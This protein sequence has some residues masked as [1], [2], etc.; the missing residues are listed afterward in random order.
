MVG[1]AQ[2]K[3]R[4]RREEM[5]WEPNHEGSH[6][7]AEGFGLDLTGKTEKEKDFSAGRRCDSTCILEGQIVCSSNS[8]RCLI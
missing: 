3:R 4:G 7:H 8:L 6:R 1:C 2:D 5:R